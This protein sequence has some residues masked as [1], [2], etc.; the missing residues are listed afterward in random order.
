[1]TGN[2]DSNLGN[3]EHEHSVVEKEVAGKTVVEKTV[4][5]KTV[6]EKI[7]VEKIVVG[8]ISTPHGVKG[9]VKVFSFTDPIDNILNYQPWYIHHQDGWKSVEVGQGRV[10]GKTIVAHIEGIDDRDSA[11]RLKGFEIAV[12][13]D[14]LPE[15]EADEFY[16][17][18]LIGLQ[19][20]NLQSKVLGTV[21]HL[22]ETGANDVL[23]IKGD[24][25][26]LVPFVLDEFIK[27]VDLKNK[28]MLVDW[29]ADF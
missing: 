28:K 3:S 2:E 17:I 24:K 29:D 10:H 1:M 13:R 9:W 6:V 25:E 21:D 4:V 8:K 7:V 14:Q 27:E 22:M 18:D 12:Q 20:V 26:H 16:W 19:V 5:E 23:V 15:V 11:E